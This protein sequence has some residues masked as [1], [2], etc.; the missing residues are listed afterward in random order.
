M[1]GTEHNAM[2]ESSPSRDTQPIDETQ[3][4]CTIDEFRE[5]MAAI[6]GELSK[7]MV[8]QDV[9]ISRLLMSLF[10]QGHVLLEGVPG[11]GKTL[12]L[13]SLAECLGLDCKRVQFTPDLMPADIVGTRIFQQQSDGS[14]FIFERGPVFT[15]LLLADEINRA[16]PK[17]QSA[18]LEA[19][20]ERQVTSGGVTHRLPQPFMVMASQNPIEMEGTYPLPEA[21]LDRFMF[22]LE[23]P[24]PDQLELVEIAVRTTGGTEA[25]LNRVVPT[26][27][28]LSRWIEVIRQIPVAR[29]LL[30]YAA[31]L[32][33]STHPESGSAIAKKFIRFG[34]SPR[35]MQSLILAAKARAFLVGRTAV[36][37]DDIVDVAQSCL[38]HRLIL[39]FEAESAGVRP[40]AVVEQLLRQ[41]R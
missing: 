11:L 1:K 15:N 26:A 5:V 38:Q 30:D 32:V 37:R 16:T 17:T 34:A 2:I 27:D 18:L 14:S 20:Q 7:V 24:F 12:L 6:R 40:A 13:K 23:V 9:V 25:K 3:L 31:R 28:H 19:M 8:G 22:K 41:L 39:N 29:P 35:G 33:V 4:Q 21:Q 10:L 36:I